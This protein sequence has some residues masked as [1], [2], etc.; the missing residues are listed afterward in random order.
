MS[1]ASI[2]LEAPL[3]GQWAILNPPGHSHLAF[4]FVAVDQAKWVYKQ[5]CLLPH[6]LMTIPVSA[7]YSWSQPV[8]APLDGIVVACKDDTPDQELMGLLRDVIRIK[9]FPPP[10][11]SPFAA[12]G[13]NYVIL[14]CGQVFPL[15]CH[16]R[17]GSVRVQPGDFV[18][19]GDL[20]GE[21]GNSGGSLLPHLHLQVMKNADPFPLFQNLLPFK[22]R[23]V[24]KR[25]GKDW[26]KVTDAVLQNGDHLKLYN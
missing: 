11:G 2:V 7:T 12:Y 5:T 24:Y 8:Y 9:A 15:L 18:Q 10:S 13:G 21:V 23:E 6:I 16:L 3:K 20:I 25:M 4:D 14:Q 19:A 22:L 1:N 26:A 17:C